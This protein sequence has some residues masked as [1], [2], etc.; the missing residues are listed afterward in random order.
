MADERRGGCRLVE[1][2]VVR[3]LRVY[4]DASDAVVTIPIGALGP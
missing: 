2:L 1:S 4:A 3:D